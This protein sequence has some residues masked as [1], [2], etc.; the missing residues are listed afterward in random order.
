MKTKSNLL[1]AGLWS[2]V[3]GMLCL[4]FPGKGDERATLSAADGPPSKLAEA[5]PWSQI[6]ATAGAKYTGEGLAVSPT[7]T[8]A[9]W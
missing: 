3:L 1:Q 2:G 4:V 8:P 6:G 9:L 7:A 5:I